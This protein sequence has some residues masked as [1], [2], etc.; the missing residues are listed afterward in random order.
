MPTREELKTWAI[1]YVELWNK[2]E[3]D[4]WIAS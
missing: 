2:G 4:A 3:K 1:N